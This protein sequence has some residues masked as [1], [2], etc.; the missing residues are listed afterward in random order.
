MTGARLCE[1]QRFRRGE[2]SPTES[3][4]FHWALRLRLTEPRSTNSKLTLAEPRAVNSKLTHYPSIRRID[5]RC[6]CFYCLQRMNPD[7]HDA[8]PPDD[9]LPPQLASPEA[10]YRWC[11]E[12]PEGLRQMEM[13]ARRIELGEFGDVT[14]EMRAMVAK[15]IDFR[16]KVRAAAAANAEMLAVVAAV[17]AVLI[18]HPSTVSSAHLVQQLTEIEH[19]LEQGEATKE[20][21]AQFRLQY[22][23]F[24]GELM[25][26][27]WK[28]AALIALSAEAHWLRDP[29][30]FAHDANAQKLIRWWREEGGRE[31]WLGSL[32]IAERCELEALGRKWR[33]NPPGTKP[34]GPPAG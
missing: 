15:L 24:Q 31:K 34:D 21:W 4:G 14:P 10:F 25:G 33:E 9:D 13:T 16:A 22:E 6:R 17:R 28:Q 19:R 30:R 32:P 8:P 11:R 5:R 1:P 26:S 12:N 7:S 20:D 23:A 29:Q 18:Q 3:N 27:I 2:T